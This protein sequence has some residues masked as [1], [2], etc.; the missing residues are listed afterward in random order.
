MIDSIALYLSSILGLCKKTKFPGTMA[1]FASLFFSFLA[2]YFFNKTIYISLFFVF[3]VFGFWAIRKIHKKNGIGDYQWIGIDE[4]TG[5]WLANFFLF[6]LNFNLTQAIIFSLISFIIFRMIDITKF[7]PPIRTINED[8]NQNALAVILDDIV[9]GV[10]TYLIML[11]ILGIYDLRFF[12]SSFLI[13]FT[14]MI[15]NMTP[16]LIK[17]KYWN[18]P[19][20]EKV[21]GKNKTWRGFLG[22][23]IVGTLFYFILVRLN[24]IIFPVDLNLIIFVGFLFSFGAIGGDLIKSFFKRKIGIL[25]GESWVP[26]DQIDYILGMI[27]L[28]Y[29]VYQYSFN[30]IILLLVMGGAI[31]ALA[32]RFGY[33]IKINS[34]KQ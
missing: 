5:M 9:A 28:T 1:S 24:I 21:L 17:M 32:H 20:G 6:E 12:Y 3:L 29:F 34:A 33:I 14:P 16:T 10:Y 15:A 11:I 4:W 7:I 23:I 13:L 27:I 22:A 31:S 26:W 25:A 19:I 2:Y 18:T 30:Q 8:K